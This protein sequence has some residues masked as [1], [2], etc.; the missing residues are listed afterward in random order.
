MRRKRTFF[1]DLLEALEGMA[2]EDRRELWQAA[3]A[4]G[5]PL[6]YFVLDL[7]NRH[8]YQRPPS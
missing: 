7:Y 6:E 5:V 4:A 2:P 3:K 1:A 8:W